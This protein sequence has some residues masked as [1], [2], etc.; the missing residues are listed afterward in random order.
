MTHRAQKTFSF[1]FLC[2]LILLSLAFNN[3][4]M[5]EQTQNTR[6]TPSPTNTTA[7]NANDPLSIHRRAIAIDMHADTTQRMVDERLDINRR[8]EDGQL[9]AVRM[10]EGGLDAQAVYAD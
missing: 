5:S 2:G 4:R 6:T 1:L 8:L 9:D 7:N 10:R 3:C